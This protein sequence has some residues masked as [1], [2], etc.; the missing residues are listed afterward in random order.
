MGIIRILSAKGWFSIDQYNNALL[1]LGYLSYESGDK[2]CPLPTSSKVKKLKGK[3]VS[4]WVHLRNW[5]L[6]MKRYVPDTE[7][8]VLL[9]G[10][11]LHDIVERLCAQ[12][13]FPYEIKVLGG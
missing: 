4:N 5:P 10:L 3:A 1:R 7:D 2:P 13:F 9:L 11:N 12:E 8:R 6:V